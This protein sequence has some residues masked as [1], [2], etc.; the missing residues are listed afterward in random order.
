MPGATYSSDDEVAVATIDKD[1]TRELLT[2]HFLTDPGQTASF[3]VYVVLTTDNEA[4]SNAVAVS[5]PV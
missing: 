4:G 3:K 1:A 5:R 2:D